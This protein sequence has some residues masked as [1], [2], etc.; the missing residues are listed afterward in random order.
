MTEQ[1]HARLGRQL[2]LACLLALAF[3]VAWIFFITPFGKVCLTAFLI[4]GGMCTK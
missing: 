1:E 3:V 2:L 4:F